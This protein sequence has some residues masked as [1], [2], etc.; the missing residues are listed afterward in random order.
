MRF[1]ADGEMLLLS[2][3]LMASLFR[4]LMQL[5]K[6]KQRSGFNKEKKMAH[7]LLTNMLGNT[8]VSLTRVGLQEDGQSSP[9][10][11]TLLFTLADGRKF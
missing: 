7:K 10:L 9:L 3:T 11:D 4:F 2:G 1:G 8:I 5:E 6:D